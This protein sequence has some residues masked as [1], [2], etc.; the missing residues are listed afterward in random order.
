[1]TMCVNANVKTTIERAIAM[2]TSVYKCV[3]SCRSTFVRCTLML[4]NGSFYNKHFMKNRCYPKHFLHQMSPQLDLH[5][6]VKNVLCSW[7][8]V[9]SD[10][11][12][13]VDT[14]RLFHIREVVT[15]TAWAT[16]VAPNCWHEDLNVI[17]RWS[18]DSGISWPSH[19]TNKF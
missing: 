14:G 4:Y 13:M 9:V 16:C 2:S 17:K 7:W 6:N 18:S 12:V 10:D 11:T 5:K 15:G 19:F 3:P 8:K 1:M